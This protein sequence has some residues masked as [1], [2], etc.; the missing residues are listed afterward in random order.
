MPPDARIDRWLNL[1]VSL[2][3]VTALIVGSVALVVTLLFN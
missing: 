2:S 1:M 3:V